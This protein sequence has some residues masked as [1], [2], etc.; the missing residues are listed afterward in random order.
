MRN[1]FKCA[2]VPTDP[3]VSVRQFDVADWQLPRD[4]P[5]RTISGPVIMK[6]RRRITSIAPLTIIL[7]R[8]IHPEQCSE[9][10]PEPLAIGTEIVAA[11]PGSAS[12]KKE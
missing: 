11:R 5:G 7:L 1:C 2:T 12:K 8:S 6:L 4:P 9:I 3:I 10:P